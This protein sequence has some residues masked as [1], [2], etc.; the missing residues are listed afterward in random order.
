MLLLRIDPTKILQPS[1]FIGGLEIGEPV[2]SI[3][4]LMISAMSLYAWWRLGKSDQKGLTFVFFRIFFLLTGIGTF[5]GGILGHAFLYKVG[6]EWKLIG[7]YTGMLAVAA[8]ERSAIL[9]ANRFIKPYVGKVFL[10]INMLELIIMMIFT[11]ITLHFQFVEYHSAYGMLLVVF[12]FHL[13]AYRK[14][15]DPGSLILLWN[16]PLLLLIVFCFNYPVILHEW[17]N[18]RDIAHVLMVISIWLMM[19]A[20][21]RMGKEGALK[22]ILSTNW[23]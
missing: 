8:I 22:P 16:T 21:L 7:F 5:C 9:H 11:T 2:T 4:D 6:P 14:S 23:S 19:H 3:T 1:I 15:K 18:H 10:V 12:G 20:S 17:F 13:Y